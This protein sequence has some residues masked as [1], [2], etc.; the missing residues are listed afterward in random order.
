MSERCRVVWTNAF[1]NSIENVKAILETLLKQQ[2]K[3]KAMPRKGFG[4]S[5]QDCLS[6]QSFRVC[7]SYGRK[8]CTDELSCAACLC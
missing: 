3:T 6:I 1:D 8:W 2:R 7:V 4:R 5:V